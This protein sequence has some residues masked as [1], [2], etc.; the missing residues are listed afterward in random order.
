MIWKEVVKHKKQ[1]ILK[2]ITLLARSYACGCLPII[3]DD[4]GVNFYL[5]IDHQ[6]ELLSI[7]LQRIAADWIHTYQ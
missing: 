6:M 7:A 2:L 4:L 1:I 5:I 3:D